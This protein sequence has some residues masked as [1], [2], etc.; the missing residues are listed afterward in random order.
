MGARTVRQAAVLAGGRGSRLGQLTISTPRPLLRCGDRPF[1]AWLLRELCRFGIEEVIILTGHLGDEIEAG[2]PSPNH[3]A[4]S[5]VGKSIQPGLAVPY[6]MPGSI[7]PI[8]FCF[9]T[10][11]LGRISM[12]PACWPMLLGT[13][14]KSSGG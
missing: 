1:L 4:S 2:L 13:L 7:L 14:K 8:G 5:V 9:A 10:A 11:T 12:L 3:Y 6:L